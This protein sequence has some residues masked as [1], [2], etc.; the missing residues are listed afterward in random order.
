MLVLCDSM[1][2]ATVTSGTHGFDQTGRPHGACYLCCAKCSRR[3]VS[4]AISRLCMSHLCVNRDHLD[5]FQIPVAKTVLI[6]A[7][8]QESVHITVTVT[9][10]QDDV[11]DSCWY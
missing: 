9:N 1:G 11:M 5:S 3:M 8:L 10:L 7:N 2:D 4:G 6:I